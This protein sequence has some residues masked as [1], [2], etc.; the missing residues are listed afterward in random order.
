MQLTGST[1]HLQGC[2]LQ[3]HTHTIYGQLY[4]LTLLA[5]SSL[6]TTMCLWITCDQVPILY[7]CRE[8]RDKG[9]TLWWDRMGNTISWKSDVIFLLLHN[10]TSCGGSTKRQ[11]TEKGSITDRYP[12][13]AQD[14]HFFHIKIEAHLYSIYTK[15][16]YFDPWSVVL[17]KYVQS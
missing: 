17:Y 1:V 12:G 13:S 14:G 15:Y 6:L 5:E 7:I 4:Y 16:I 2:T 9:Q 11:D 3:T 10:G 8:F